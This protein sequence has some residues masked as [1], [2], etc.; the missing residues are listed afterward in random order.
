[1]R[2]KSQ[3]N[4]VAERRAGH[5]RQGTARC[6]AEAGN[7]TILSGYVEECAGLIRRHSAWTRSSGC[8]RGKGRTW[9]QGKGPG[10]GYTERRDRITGL[11]THKEFAVVRVQHSYV[12]V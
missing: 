4:S 1:M 12:G 7:S 6:D 11:V 3:R 5:G 8:Y 10:C 9:N 2:T